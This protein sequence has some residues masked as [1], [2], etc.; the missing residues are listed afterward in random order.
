MK[1]YEKGI[2][3]VLAIII[4]LVISLFLL[5]LNGVRKDQITSVNL[6]NKSDKAFELC[7]AGIEWAARYLANQNQIGEEIEDQ[8]DPLT[9][10]PLGSGN[11][12]CNITWHYDAAQG[13]Y[14]IK[15]EATQDGIHRSL[16]VSIQLQN[17]LLDYKVASWGGDEAKLT[18]TGR[19]EGSVFADSPVDLYFCIA[20]QLA[21]TQRYYK[22]TYINKKLA[23]ISSD[24]IKLVN[25]IAPPTVSFSAYK[26]DAQEAKIYGKGFYYP[27]DQTIIFDENYSQDYFKDKIVYADGDL[28]IKLKG[29]LHLFNYKEAKMRCNNTVFVAKGNLT[30]TCDDLLFFWR[31]SIINVNNDKLTLIAGKKLTFDPQIITDS[32]NVNFIGMW[33]SGE[34]I[35]L[36]PWIGGKDIQLDGMVIA[37]KG[38]TVKLWVLKNFFKWQGL[39]DAHLKMKTITF[40]DWQE[41]HE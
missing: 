36:E 35:D 27:G 10:E 31:S 9:E 28:T 16:Q 23:L 37:K 17:P 7:E 33:Y 20:D 22:N 19:V 34:E 32:A 13:K 14:I 15:S 12:F 24:Q 2:A 41:N 38:G 6:K 30:I 18:L 25:Y 21:V 3:L 39:D 4:V 26:K 29:H 8:N 40:S 11:G 1:Q 5:S